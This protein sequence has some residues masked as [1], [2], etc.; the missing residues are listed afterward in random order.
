MYMSLNICM[1]KVED[2]EAPSALKPS[3]LGQQIVPKPS[4]GCI[5]NR[6]GRIAIKPR[7]TSVYTGKK[8]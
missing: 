3:T 4:D 5:C 8:E 6:D 1:P 7:S 2:A